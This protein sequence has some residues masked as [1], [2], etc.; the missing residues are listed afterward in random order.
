[1][2]L[3]CFAIT[4]RQKGMFSCQNVINLSYVCV[5]IIRWQTLKSAQNNKV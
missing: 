5:H 3:F 4:L 1:M 2:V